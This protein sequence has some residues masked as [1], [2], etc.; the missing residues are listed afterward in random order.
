MTATLFKNYYN[1]FIN[2]VHAGD[3]LFCC[4]WERV[5]IYKLLVITWR[6]LSLMMTWSYHL[7]NFTNHWIY[8][9]CKVVN[10]SFDCTLGK[11]SVGLL[12]P[13]KC[14]HGTW[15]FVNP[16]PHTTILQQTTLKVFC[17]KIENLYNWID[18]LSLKMENIVAKGEIAR[19]E[20]FILLTLCFKK[21]V[22][23]RGIRKHIYEGKA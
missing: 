6:F 2:T 9:L 16:F 11:I 1:S 3:K 13:K 19:F 20:Q 7:L 4:K 22:C 12:Q 17:Q 10:L 21:A 8:W 23:C 5:N 18:N 14:G 15:T